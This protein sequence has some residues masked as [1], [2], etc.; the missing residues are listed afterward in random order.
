MKK[1]KNTV[2]KRENGVYGKGEKGAFARKIWYNFIK[3]SV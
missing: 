3:I 1:G 2:E